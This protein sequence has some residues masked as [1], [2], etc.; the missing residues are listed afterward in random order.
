M[1]KA[2]K[3]LVIF[4]F[5]AIYMFGSTMIY[6]SENQTEYQI[7]DAYLKDVCFEYSYLDEIAGQRNI[8][9]ID[10]LEDMLN[11]ITACKLDN[12]LSKYS[13]TQTP[14]QDLNQL[15]EKEKNII[16][17]AYFFGA[18]PDK[19]FLLPQR[20][21]SR[22]DAARIAIQLYGIKVNPLL[23]ESQNLF[24]DI[25][26]EDDKLIANLAKNIGFP[27]T[28]SD[29]FSPFVLMNGEDFLMWLYKI[30][31]SVRLLNQSIKNLDTESSSGQ[32]DQP[33]PNPDDFTNLSDANLK[34]IVEIWNLVKTYLVSPTDKE[35]DY[36][37]LEE[38][39]LQNLFQELNQTVDPYA[40]YVPQSLLE[41]NNNTDEY[42]G[43]GASLSINENGEVYIDTVFT[44]SPAE[45]AGLKA[46][47]IIRKIDNTEI[48]DMTTTDVA[49]L[50][51]GKAGTSVKLT[52]YRSSIKQELIKTAIR[53]KIT[54]TLVKSEIVKYGDK[55]FLN[56]II[57]TFNKEGVIDIFEEHLKTALA[58]ETGIDGIV[59]DL[60]GNGGGL[61]SEVNK[62]IEMFLPE[63]KKGF[64]FVYNNNSTESFI[65]ETPAETDLPLAVIVNN[66][67]A[68]ASEIFV[69]AMQDFGRGYIVGEKTHGKFVAQ[70]LFNLDKTT[71]AEVR[72][73]IAKWYSP[74]GRLAPY[75]PDFVTSDENNQ[76][77]SAYKWL[78]T[79]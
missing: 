12:F 37:D 9:R 72:F 40:Y 70:Q 21:I 1:K 59:I 57:N 2:L 13:Q 5:L 20:F 36:T 32:T 61:V 66:A 49:Q 58:S 65:T 22:I 79:Q 64:S 47:D 77:T 45:K 28:D 18:L 39:V 26:N 48:K 29:K 10:A 46:L 43:I 24:L 75:T 17:M 76:L 14:Y 71:K 7:A 4:G 63:G 69:G 62:L 55:Y 78:A 41:L 54:L 23:T 3:N 34:E 35:I 38:A 74:K 51:R 42:E 25:Q 27:G 44:D 56:S 33:A 6:A 67:S 8:T 16:K 68:S 15:T 50:I 19:D 11:L 52:I 30:D 31:N 60:R 73:T 53:A